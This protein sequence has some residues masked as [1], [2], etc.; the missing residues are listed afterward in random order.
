MKEKLTLLSAAL[1]AATAAWAMPGDRLPDKMKHQRRSAVERREAPAPRAYVAPAAPADKGDVRLDSIVGRTPE[2]KYDTKTIVEYVDTERKR[3]ETPYYYME[4]W[5]VEQQAY[6]PT[7]QPMGNRTETASDEQGRLTLQAYYWW[8]TEAATWQG[9]YRS[10]W[11]YSADGREVTETYSNW[12]DGAWAHS[13]KYETTYD[14]VGNVLESVSYQW[15]AATQAWAGDDRTVSTYDDRGNTLTD[16]S[17]SWD[18]DT[19][20]WTEEDFM[21]WVLDPA[22]YQVDTIYY[23]YLEEGAWHHQRGVYEWNDHGGQIRET[24]YMKN[25]AGE[26]EKTADYKYE[27]TYDAQGRRAQTIASE[28]Y[29]D[30]P[31][32]TYMYKAT[33]EYADN[34]TET[35]TQYNYVDGEWVPDTKYESL[36]DDEGRTLIYS[37]LQ[38]NA[39]TNRWEAQEY[40]ERQVNDYDDA[41]HLTLYEL[42]RWDVDAQE[43]NVYLR[44]EWGYDEHGNLTL[45]AYYGESPETGAYELQY[46]RTNEYDY[47]QYGNALTRRYYDGGELMEIHEYFYS[48]NPLAPTTG[49]ATVAVPTPVVYVDGADIRLTGLADAAVT[50]HDL[51]GRIVATAPATDGRATI[52]AP[53]PGLYVVRCGGQS[54]KVLVR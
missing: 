48:P 5:S 39:E 24:M 34:G 25:A 41:G 47:D 49:Q 51:G 9:N 32:W 11:V 18:A 38:W 17:Y 23:R 31:E 19:K 3:I 8:N 30:A 28:W 42:Y 2:G 36:N 13:S 7:W 45:E 40:N 27:D 37:H 54:V 46:R 20:Q 16:T 21:E 6:I 50:L 43:W 52:T 33:Y 53:A 4:E 22:T 44:L 1:V 15:D 12:Q 26:W 10:E 14:A 29:A 35:E